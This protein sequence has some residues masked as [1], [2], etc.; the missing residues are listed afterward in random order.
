MHLAFG[1]ARADRAPGDQVAEVLRRDDVEEL[2]ARR[3]AELVDLEQELAADAQPLVDPVALVEVR[4]VDQALPADRRARLLE[5]DA[6][7]DLERVP[8]KRSR[9][10][11]SRFA[12]STAATGSWI[13]HGPMMTSRRSSSRRM[14][15]RIESRVVPMSVSTG[16]PAIGKKRIR[17]SG[18]GSGV[19]FSIRRSSVRLV[20]S[21]SPYA[22]SAGGF[23]V[24]RHGGVL[25]RKVEGKKNR[26]GSPGGF[27][28]GVRP[29]YAPAS[30]TA[31]R[32]ENAKYAKNQAREIMGANVARRLG[33]SS[34][35]KGDDH[36][37][38]K[39]VVHE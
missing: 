14:I 4:V 11:L 2:A 29:A 25:Q 12:Y 24:L 20:R 17:C 7:D 19:T 10:A 9:S 18:G 31:E 30:P 21:P 37:S 8:A 36:G 38:Q 13:E 22:L 15:R 28:F 23:A 34:T 32:C 16:V 6:H 33:A 3:H 1:R 26:R 35:S 39:S 27:G 5:I